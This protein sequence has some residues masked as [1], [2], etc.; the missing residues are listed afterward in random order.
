MD[1]HIGADVAGGEVV[2]LIF[3]VESGDHAK[4]RRQREI[5]RESDGNHGRRHREIVGAPQW[6]EWRLR[7]NL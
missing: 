7:P 5:H 3:A 6:Q 4:V 2:P 1:W